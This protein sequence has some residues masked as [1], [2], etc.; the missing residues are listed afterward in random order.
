[1]ENKTRGT[2]NME[3]KT[4][5]TRNMENKTRGTR[6]PESK[7]R[8][9]RNLQNKTRGTRNP[10]NK[11]RG[12]RNMENK[13]RGT[14]NPES[15]MKMKER[16]D[17]N[18]VEEKYQDQKDHDI[19]I[20][21]PQRGPNPGHLL[22]QVTNSL[23]IVQSSVKL[24]TNITTQCLAELPLPNHYH[25]KHSSLNLHN[26]TSNNGGQRSQARSTYLPGEVGEMS[27]KPFPAL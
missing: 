26:A 20:F 10:E 12:S 5:G 11:T 3:N 14:R 6:N 15:L 16:Q 25:H 8:G 9:T 7:T 13:T 22:G 24:D 18:E 1:M 21:G 2:R 19:K 17:P 27:Q 23:Q 4:R